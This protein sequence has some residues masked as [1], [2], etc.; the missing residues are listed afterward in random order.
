[1]IVPIA[2]I[3]AIITESSSSNPHPLSLYPLHNYHLEIQ[4][5]NGNLEQ[6]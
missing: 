3:T 1:M 6:Q 5:I 4:Q 2:E